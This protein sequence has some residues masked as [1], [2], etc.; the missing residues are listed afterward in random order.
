MW[1]VSFLALWDNLGEDDTKMAQQ[2]ELAALC[3][4]KRERFEEGAEVF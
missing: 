2:I 3:G 4:T 1:C